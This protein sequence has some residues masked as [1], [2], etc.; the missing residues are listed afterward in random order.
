VTSARALLLAGCATVVACSVPGLA[1][2]GVA[3][4]RTGESFPGERRDVRGVVE[5]G[6]NSCAHLV[7]DGVSHFVIWP[8]GTAT[9]ELVLR[10]GQRVREGDTIVGRGALTPTEPLHGA[11]GET[12]YWGH[13]L[14][15]CDVEAEEVLVLDDAALVQ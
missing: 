1:G 12:T 5:G 9:W 15:L 6:P 4:Q 2:A 7:V 11:A 8:H 10:S 13:M 3:S 14:G